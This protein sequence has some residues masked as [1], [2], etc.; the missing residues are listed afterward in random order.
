VFECERIYIHLSQVD[1]FYTKDLE[2]LMS[3]IYLSLFVS[4][5]LFICRYF[6][7][8][9]FH[10]FSFCIKNLIKNQ[11]VVNKK[12]NKIRRRKINEPDEIIIK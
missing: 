4:Y 9:I 10:I 12:T 1:Y 8:K 5:I 6:S 3:T 11:W 2:V 7:K